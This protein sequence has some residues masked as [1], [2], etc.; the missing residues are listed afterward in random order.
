MSVPLSTFH[1]DYLKVRPRTLLILNFH[2]QCSQEVVIMAI[3][4]SFSSWFRLRMGDMVNKYQTNV[5]Y[6]LF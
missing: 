1:N 5:I 3:L 2:E 4:S 6:R